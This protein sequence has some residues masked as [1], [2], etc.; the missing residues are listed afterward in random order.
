MPGWFGRRRGAAQAD[1]GSLGPAQVGE[2]REDRIG[3][4]VSQAEAAAAR[5]SWGDARECYRQSAELGDVPSAFNLALLL[6]SGRGGVADPQA[7]RAWYERAAGGGDSDASLNLGLM[8][9]HGEGGP[10]DAAAAFRWVEAAGEAGNEHAFMRLGSMF[11]LGEGV[12]QNYSRAFEWFERAAQAGAPAAMYNCA[13]ACLRGSGTPLDEGMARQWFERAA[14]CGLAVAAHRLGLMLDSGQGGGID[15][16]GAA[17]W[18]RKAYLEMT[19]P[20]P[21]AANE[22]GT[23]YRLGRGVPVDPRRA[24]ECFEYAANTGVPEGA[25]NAGLLLVG[26]DADHGFAADEGRA[27]TWFES[28]LAADPG[29]VHGIELV[30]HRLGQLE[31]ASGGAAAQVRAAELFRLA[32]DRGHGASQW[33]LGSMYGSGGGVSLDEDE[34]LLWITRASARGHAEA[35]Q[36]LARRAAQ[37]GRS[38]DEPVARDFEQAIERLRRDALNGVAVAMASLGTLFEQGRGVALDLTQARSWYERSAQAGHPNGMFGLGRLFAQGLGVEPS[39]RSALSWF[40]QAA[41]MGHAGALF[42]LGV[43][44][45][46]GRGGAA[47]ADVAA[48]LFRRAA[49]LGHAQAANNLGVLYAEGEGLVPNAALAIYWFRKAA[50]RGLADG[51]LNLGLQ[52]CP[53]ARGAADEVGEAERAEGVEWLRKAARQGHAQALEELAARGI[54]YL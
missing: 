15:S 17:D 7:A 32:A 26:G 2:R 20:E 5:L 42:N 47:A 13:L 25:V 33:A 18:W 21:A 40:E 8:W 29:A 9:L 24:L 4:L 3:R 28:V 37:S 10:Q 1:P 30:W 14:R 46:E 39:D 27:R 34:A 36:W 12:A 51:Q 50:E 53:A 35:A 41:E 49:E 43:M 54:R 38:P 52:L 6:Q 44:R 11:E 48:Q 23:L 16:A 19:P 31:Q 22:L 45:Q